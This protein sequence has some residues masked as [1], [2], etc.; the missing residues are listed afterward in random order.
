MRP[1]GLPPIVLLFGGC[2]AIPYPATDDIDRN[3]LS[4][5]ETGKTRKPDVIDALGQ[6]LVELDGGR[7]LVVYDPC[8]KYGLIYVMGIAGPDGG[9][10][11][12]ARVVGQLAATRDVRPC[13]Q[14]SRNA[15]SCRG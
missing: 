8:S 4:A 11:G 9:G 3:G 15:L 13:L 5:F 2:I 12:K 14:R 1:N 6:L 10:P 7:V